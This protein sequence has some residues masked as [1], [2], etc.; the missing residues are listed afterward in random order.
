MTWPACV[1]FADY[2]E[3]PIGFDVNESPID[4]PESKQ[5]KATV[6]LPAVAPARSPGA[7]R[8]K[9]GE[10]GRSVILGK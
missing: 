2:S 6:L 1:L 8:L 9:D 7:T 4:L 5:W 10:C 3:K